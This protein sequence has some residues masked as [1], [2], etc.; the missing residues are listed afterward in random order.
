MRF[1]A[2]VFAAVTL[3]VP[4]LAGP[5]K[6]DNTGRYIVKLK[7]GTVRQDALA[8]LNPNARSRVTHEWSLINGFAGQFDPATVTALRQSPEVEFV[9]EDQ[10]MNIFGTQLVISPRIGKE[11]CLMYILL[12][13]N[14]PWGLGRLSSSSRLSGASDRLEDASRTNV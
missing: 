8:K 1:F 3:A 4:A 2:A 12:R 13:T 11:S 5:I 10:I 14:A 9:E 7:S 6:V